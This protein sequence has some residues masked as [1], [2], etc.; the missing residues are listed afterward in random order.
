MVRTLNHSRKLNLKTFE[1]VIAPKCRAVVAHGRMTIS[2]T[3]P[4]LLW[5]DSAGHMALRVRH[6]YGGH[7]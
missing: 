7:F 2:V 1:D 3:F 6:V 5:N 4:Q